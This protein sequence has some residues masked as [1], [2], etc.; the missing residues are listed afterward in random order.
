MTVPVWLLILIRLGIG[1]LMSRAGNTSQYW[2]D[3]CLIVWVRVVRCWSR[4]WL[5]NSS[6]GS[7]F[8]S[9]WSCRNMID[10]KGHYSW[11]VQCSLVYVSSC[12]SNEVFCW[13]LHSSYVALSTQVYYTQS[14]CYLVYYQINSLASAALYDSVSFPP[15]FLLWFD[16]HCLYYPTVYS[17]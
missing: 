13:S 12:T 4:L 7:S 14:L 10:S 2:S 11:L 16:C 15:S 1:Y 6:S 9:F 5:C 3:Y 8:C 17:N